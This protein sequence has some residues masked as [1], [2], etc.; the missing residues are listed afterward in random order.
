MSD[1][2]LTTDGAAAR[3]GVTPGR[4]RAMI[5]AG[6]LPAQ[7]F[8]FV[9]MIKASDL[10]IVE[11]RKVGRPAHSSASLA[12]A[13]GHARTKTGTSPRS[14]GTTRKLND[15]FKQATEAGHVSGKNGT[16]TGGRKGG[17]K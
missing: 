10:K 3:L 4:V 14:A 17:K 6:R 16:A 13:T 9:H 11:G 15:A 7:K 2:L 1:E 5:A 12:H 8:G